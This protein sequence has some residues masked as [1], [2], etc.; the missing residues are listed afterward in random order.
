MIAAAAALVLAL[1]QPPA[2]ALPVR[3]PAPARQLAP[4]DRWLGVDKA[5]HF[6]LAGFVQSVGFA[7]ATRA[8]AGRASA[9]AAAGAVTAAV[10]IGKEVRDRRVG[11]PFSTRDLVWDAAGAA[12]STALLV[13]TDG[14]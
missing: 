13:R 9:L 2:V 4:R 6:L 12:A 5:K 3:L 1:A 10:S 7:A 11:G 8:G 14:R